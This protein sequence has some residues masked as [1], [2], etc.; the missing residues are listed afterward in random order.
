[1]FTTGRDELIMSS[2]NMTVN[3]TKIDF[4]LNAVEFL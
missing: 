1:M 3:W 4:V 2:N